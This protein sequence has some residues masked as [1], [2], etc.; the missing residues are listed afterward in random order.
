MKLIIAEKKSVGETIAKVLGVKTTRNGY[1]EGDD[2]MI[3][4]CQGHLVGLALPDS[5]GEQ[6]KQYWTFDNLPI[7]PQKWI[8]ETDTAKIKQLKILKGL[9]FNSS[10][11]VRVNVFSDMCTISS[12]ATSL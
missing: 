6:Y 2:Y 3:S 8:F 10:V 5:Y 11:D 1:L 7:I 9:I 4:W 12:A